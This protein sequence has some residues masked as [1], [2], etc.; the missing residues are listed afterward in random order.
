MLIAAPAIAMAA[1]TA[2]AQPA[3]IHQVTTK[4][5]VHEMGTPVSSTVHTV[6]QPKHPAAS[7]TISHPLAR[8]STTP[9]VHQVVRTAPVTAP[10]SAPAATPVVAKTTG[11]PQ[12][13]LWCDYDSYAW[14]HWHAAYHWDAAYHNQGYNVEA[15]HYWNAGG[16]GDMSPGQVSHGNYWNAGSYVNVSQDYDH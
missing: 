3:A 14:F 10:Q 4:P 2:A 12:R 6:A 9:F 11:A 7:T 15:G 1:G 13:G 16:Y 8:T 5:V